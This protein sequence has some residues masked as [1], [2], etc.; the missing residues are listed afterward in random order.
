MK[1]KLLTA[2]KTDAAGA[3]AYYNAQEPGL[4][5]EFAAEVRK[6]IER[7][8]QFPNAWTSVSKRVRRCQVNRFP[9][10]VFYSLKSDVVVVIAVLHNHR[11]PRT[12]QTRV[13]K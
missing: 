2:A 9:Y 10:G 5:A 3:I 1:L 7:I 4:G 12:W 8:L 11:E 13:D 6:T